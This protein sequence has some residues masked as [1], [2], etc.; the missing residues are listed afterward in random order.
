MNKKKHTEK[1]ERES[2]SVYQTK[3]NKREETTRS[4]FW[5][6]KIMRANKQERK[7]KKKKIG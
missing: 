2:K 4:Q 7:E 1:R 6:E 5:R 3:R